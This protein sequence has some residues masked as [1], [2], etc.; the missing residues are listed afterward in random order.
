MPRPPVFRYEAVR[1]PSA[2]PRSRPLAPA[3]AWVLALMVVACVPGPVAAAATRTDVTRVARAP[4]E[5]NV[6]IPGAPGADANAAPHV[7]PV[8]G[9]KGRASWDVAN[10]A[11]SAGAANNVA[12]EAVNALDADALPPPPPDVAPKGK[13]AQAV[14]TQRKPDALGGGAAQGNTDARGD[15]DAL[16]NAD[17]QGNSGPAG[18]NL[19]GQ[20]PHMEFSRL[21]HSFETLSRG[22]KVSHAFPFTNTGKGTLQVRSIH[23]ACGCVNTRVEPKDTFAPGESGKVVFEFDSSLFVG[24]LVRTITVDTNARNP[25]T[26]TLTFSA[27]IVPEM[28]LRPNVITMG[29]IPK[30]FEGAF[31]V[32]VD[33][34]PRAAGE[35]GTHVRDAVNRST[36]PGALKSQVL[37][38]R[39][40]VRI[41]Q[42]ATSTPTL[43]ASVV[44]ADERKAKVRVSVRGPLPI[45]PFRERLTLWNSS[46]HMKEAV[47]A[48]TGEVVGHVKPSATYLEFGVVTGRTAVRRSLKL[49]SDQSDFKVSAVEVEV[50]RSEALKSIRAVD[51]IAFQTERTKEGV[52]V[53][54]DMRVPPA[55]TTEARNVNASGALIVRTSDP[56]YREIRVPFF[57][58]LR[59][60][61]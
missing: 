53:H 36:L 26:Q 17:A 41:V 31:D 56:D 22:E 21:R 43:V 46:R 19:Q 10:A 15:A 9:R 55:L 24:P 20:T 45:G 51:L 47:V 52:V 14:G 25:S 6:A 13:G 3:L 23:A 60:N 44:D 33:F 57:G 12:T 1:A 40:P 28:I 38:A 7:R 8:Q 50:R 16:G 49:A 37:A 18:E 39:G 61:E 32:E 59:R 30:E 4:S 54:F 29:E 35:T 27:D 48:I 11:P 42:A 5:G 2:L 58:V 34:A